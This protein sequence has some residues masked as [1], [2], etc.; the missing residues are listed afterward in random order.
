MRQRKTAAAWW[1]SNRDNSLLEDTEESPE[2]RLLI[3]L[4]QKSL[5]DLE[6]TS[7]VSVE[8]RRDAI[9]WFSL[10]FSDAG[11]NFGFVALTLEIPSYWIAIIQEKIKA[12]KIYNEIHFKRL[13][14][15]Q[16]EKRKRNRCTQVAIQA[17]PMVP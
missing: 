9:R 10:P 2:R 5:S 12:A 4:F 7:C 14:T 3:A 11:F 16:I 13:Q 6:A 1:E 15:G 8:D 17:M